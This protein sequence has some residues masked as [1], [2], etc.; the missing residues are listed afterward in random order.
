MGKILRKKQMNNAIITDLQNIK[1]LSVPYLH[2]DI[3]NGYVS[4]RAK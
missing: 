2:S 3:I 4:Q 1:T